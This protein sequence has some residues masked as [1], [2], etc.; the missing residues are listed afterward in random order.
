MSNA[1]SKNQ[2]SWTQTFTG[3]DLGGGNADGGGADTAHDD[4]NGT[5]RQDT[6][7]ARP[8]P[9]PGSP[10]R[11]AAPPGGPAAPGGA[12]QQKTVDDAAKQ[13]N[14]ESE[15]N[16]KKYLPAAKVKL[17]KDLFANGKPTGEAR[18]AQIKLYKAMFLDPGFMKRENERGDK[19]AA[20]LKG[21]KDIRKDRKDWKTV[22]PAEKVKT[23]QKIV[24]AQSKQY[25]FPPP[26]IVLDPPKPPKNGS[27][28]NG[29]FLAPPA[30]D[31]KIHLNPYVDPDNPEDSASFGDFEQ[32]VTTV[33]HENG[34]NYQAR[35]V[36]DL[37]A[38][39]IK[40]G[41]PDYAQASMF[42]VNDD[43]DAYIQFKEDRDAYKRQ[44]EEDHSRTMGPA[45]AG[46]LT[47]A[48]DKAN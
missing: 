7:G 15:E 34:H 3:I 48:L 44:P 21:D 11:G 10:A 14:V 36:K 45:T 13:V 32:A 1:L 6:G 35:L 4:Q 42:D 8:A 18:K 25:G 24:D 27:I 16:L 12:A 47:K 23:L 38:G 41:D 26:R 39:K 29:Q 17:V 22:L 2:L 30:G 46:K 20:E 37:R 19:I 43:G 33:L 9:A 40:P 31:G 28:T 5:A